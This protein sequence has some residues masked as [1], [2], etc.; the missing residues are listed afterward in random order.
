MGSWLVYCNFSNITITYGQKCVLVPLLEMGNHE[1]GIGYTNIRLFTLPIYG[2]YDDYGRIDDIEE[3][4]NTKLIEAT[5]D[6]KIK[7]FADA[8]TDG[9]DG[10][11]IPILKRFKN[12]TYC[13][14]N[15]EVWDFMASVKN[16]D[17]L[18]AHM[19]NHKLL[20]RLGFNYCGEDETIERYKHKYELNGAHVYSDGNFIKDYIFRPKQLKE[21]VPDVALTFFDDTDEFDLW[22]FYKSMT[23]MQKFYSL[24]GIDNFISVFAKMDD[25]EYN[26]EFFGSSYEREY[27]KLNPVQRA[28]Y[29]QRKNPIIMNEFAAVARVI[30]HAYSFSNYLKPYVLFITPQCGEHGEHQL[31]LDKFREINQ[32]IVNEKL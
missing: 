15:R 6:C 12:V 23:I 8:L 10:P 21:H 27:N 31:F 18:F 25:G 24:M 30:K 5:F 26:T 20:L 16:E 22:P 11:E 9:R 4:E 19:G 7:D 1:I 14:V 32:N 13:W 17:G 3:T 2:V 29:D 28:Y